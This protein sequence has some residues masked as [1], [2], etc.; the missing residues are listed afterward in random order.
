MT[1]S[2]YRSM[3]LGIVLP[4]NDLVVGTPELPLPRAAPKEGGWWVFV[5]RLHQLVDVVLVQWPNLALGRQR[6]GG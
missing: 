5:V 2:L 6:T 3:A 1:L 4:Y